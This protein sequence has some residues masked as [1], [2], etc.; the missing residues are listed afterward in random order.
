VCAAGKCSS[1]D[2]REGTWSTSRSLAA[3]CSV[4][5]WWWAACVFVSINATHTATNAR[6]YLQLLEG[7]SSA[8]E[9]VMEM[10]GVSGKSVLDRK[11]GRARAATDDKGRVS[12]LRPRAAQCRLSLS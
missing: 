9:R 12:G 11:L 3:T 10:V 8:D 4:L 6:S 2:Q 1:E 7:A 5:T